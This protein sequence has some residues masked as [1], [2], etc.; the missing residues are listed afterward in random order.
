VGRREP[1]PWERNYV[2]DPGPDD[3]PLDWNEVEAL[4]G[5]GCKFGSH[6][7]TH[8]ELDRLP[9]E[10]AREEIAGSRRR[11][12]ERLGRDVALFCYPRGACTPVLAALVAAAGYAAAV[13][14]PR[15][16]GLAEHRFCLR[17]TGIYAADRGW[18][19]RLKMS[20]AFEPL[21]EARLRW[22]FRKPACS[23]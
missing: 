2:P 21:R 16:A 11:L 15:R 10:A 7:L 14:T 3:R 17:R 9:E 8:P 12:A 4:A 18:R 1:F 13:V 5:Q 19:Y 6:T 20:P 22:S 23:S